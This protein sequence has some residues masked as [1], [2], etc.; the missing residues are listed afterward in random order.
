MVI[1]RIIGGLGNQLFQYAAGRRLAALHKVPLR[2]DISGFE[3]YKLHKYSLG[4]FNISEEFADPGDVS[5]FKYRSSLAGKF[6]G[7]FLRVFGRS[8]AFSHVREKKFSFDPVIALRGGDVYL[9][10][11]WQSEKYFKDIEPLIRQDFSFKHSPD[12]VNQD[13]VRQIANCN[14]VSVHIRRGDY[15]SNPETNSI[16]GTSSMEYYRSAMR[17]L[18]N[19]NPDARFFIFTDDPAWVGKNMAFESPVELLT[20]NDANKN[21]ED[22]RLMSLC[23]HNIIANSSFSW[24]GAWLNSNPEKIVVAPKKW[25]N[26]LSM[27]TKDLIPENWV[28]I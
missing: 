15:V 7:F 3:G 1:V 21:Y 22:M 23:K 6:Y 8:R 4:H 19:K 14:S 2:L 17:F 5:G 11:Y 26:D 25:F 28:R 20:H 12:Q 27:D 18:L 24:W 13:A 10:G 9:D 16:H